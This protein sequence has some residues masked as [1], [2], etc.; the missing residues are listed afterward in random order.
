MTSPLASR[1]REVGANTRYDVPLVAIQAYQYAAAVL[2]RSAR[3][4]HLSWPLIAAIGQVES[5]HGRYGG[6]VVLADGTTSPSIFGPALNGRGDVQRITDTD[7]GRLDGDR[8]WDRAV[9]PMQILPSTWAIIGV[10]GDQDGVRNLN[11]F[12]DA[13]L[14]TGSYLCAVA[15]GDLRQSS[16]ARHAVYGYNHSTA[17]VD[18]VLALAAA[19]AHGAAKVIG[20]DLLTMPSS[21]LPPE[22]AAA[23]KGS[24]GPA[25]NSSPVIRRELHRAS[26]NGDRTTPSGH[27]RGQRPNRREGSAPNPDLVAAVIPRPGA[28]DGGQPRQPGGQHAPVVAGEPIQ[29]PTPGATPTPP[30][31]STPQPEPTP[32]PTATPTPDP[33]ATPTPTPSPQPEPTPTPTPQ[34][35]P[36][37]T[38]TPLLTPAPVTT[39]ITGTLTACNDSWCL[40]DIPV[41]LGRDPDLSGV[42]GDYDGDGIAESVS[43]E[44]TGLL[45]TSV[46]VGIDAGG[47]VLEINRLPYVAPPVWRSLGVRFP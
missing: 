34:P 15:G 42:Q 30:P 8:V 4:C 10:D 43:Q 36:T 26:S 27:P 45:R 3:T 20:T 29:T 33:A 5:D 39:R 2:H 9:G 17:Y 28:P 47:L 41:L 6:A 46:E 40:D 1:I 12:N 44:L 7:H 32:T 19:Y 14:A 24:P 37:P 25:V 38:P 13:A 35:E 11:D 16:H 18:L 21:G 22:G 23:A 31:P